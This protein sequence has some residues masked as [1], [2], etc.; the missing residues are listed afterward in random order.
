MSWGQVLTAA[1]YWDG[2]DLLRVPTSGTTGG[3][4]R[5]VLRTVRSWTDSFEPFTDCTGIDADD[6]VL[7]SGPASSMFVFARAHAA[8]LGAR[9]IA[10]PRWRP[11]DAREATV[12]HL[13]TTML[14]DVLEVDRPRLRLAVVAGAALAPA[15]R[16]RA[17]AE[18]IDVVEY[19]GAAE[20]SFVGIGRERLEPFPGAEVAVG[21][22]LIWVRSPWTA[23]G[24]AD[25]AT[26]PLRT[27]G[28][29]CSV[30]DRGALVDGILTVHGRD[31]VVTTGGT[32]VPVADVE[33]VV[34]AAPGV[35]DVAVLGLPH[36][37]LGEVLT[38]V[39]VGGD[40]EQTVGHVRDRLP[41]EQ[42]PV[43]WF[44]ADR[45]P[46]TATG[47]VSLADLRL[48]LAAGEVRRWS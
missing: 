9:V 21:G 25:G 26:G 20:L 40:R 2:G 17:R 22:D 31:D 43:H 14:A 27:D 7:A 5:T 3:A 37:R 24:Y 1:G 39:V 28:A 38:A 19:Y 18:G 33:T 30:G 35:R 23:L 16:D 41:R 29:W 32:S 10:G 48:A 12:A 44:T 4:P 36:E 13:T 15:L 45:L 11:D 47:K 42:R 46:A 8:A 34:R 6:V